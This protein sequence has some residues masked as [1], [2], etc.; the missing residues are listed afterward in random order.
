MFVAPAPR[1]YFRPRVGF[2]RP[3]YASPDLVIVPGHWL[4]YL[5]VH[6][7][8]DLDGPVIASTEQVQ[9]C[10]TRERTHFVQHGSSAFSKKCLDPIQRCRAQL[11]ENA[12]PK[13]L[14][15]GRVDAVENGVCS[16]ALHPF[17]A[18]LRK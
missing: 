13:G 14:R 8:A 11:L 18:A 6:H 2:L 17:R 5:P 7:A 3:D 15:D 16:A 10:Y 4:L 1:T 9:G 12:Q